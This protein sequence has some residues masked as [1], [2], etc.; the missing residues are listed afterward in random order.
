MYTL[1]VIGLLRTAFE[2][3]AVTTVNVP[4]LSYKECSIQADQIALDIRKNGDKV[5]S[6]K[7]ILQT[8]AKV[9]W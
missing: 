6:T 1:I 3:A 4:N 9:S 7:C 8:P 5:I 2:T